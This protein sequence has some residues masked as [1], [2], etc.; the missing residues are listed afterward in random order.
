MSKY[1]KYMK[2]SYDEAKKKI[3]FSLVPG[4][5]KINTIDKG[6]CLHNNTLT[7]IDDFAIIKLPFE[8]DF[9]TLSSIEKETWEKFWKTCRDL[10]KLLKKF[11]SKK[12][13]EGLNEF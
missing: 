11:N 13:L 7:V 1:S 6:M 3:L 2:L 9:D 12:L 8:A 5:K 10:Y 4:S